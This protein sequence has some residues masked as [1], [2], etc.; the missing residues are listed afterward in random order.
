MNGKMGPFFEM[1]C[2][3]TER[4]LYRGKESADFDHEMFDDNVKVEEKKL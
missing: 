1:L 2:L 4:K 3:S